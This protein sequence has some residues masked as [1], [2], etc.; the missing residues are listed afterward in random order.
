MYDILNSN[1][2]DHKV[3]VDTAAKNKLWWGYSKFHLVCQ[4]LSS[5]QTGTRATSGL[6][7]AWLEQFWLVLSETLNAE[8]TF[9]SQN[10]CCKVDYVHS[11]WIKGSFYYA[12][13]AL[14]LI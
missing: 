9:S 6:C 10:G 14:K 3:P 8:G 5:E 1:R 13:F 12:I 7:L 11:F 4:S 2:T